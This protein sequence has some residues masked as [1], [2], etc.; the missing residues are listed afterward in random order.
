MLMTPRM[1]VAAVQ[2]LKDWDYET[3]RLVAIQAS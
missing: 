2:V 3:N 1:K